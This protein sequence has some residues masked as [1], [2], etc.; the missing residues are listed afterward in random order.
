MTRFRRLRQMCLLATLLSK[1]K[2]RKRYKRQ[3]MDQH[4]ALEFS[5]LK[6][7]FLTSNSNIQVLDVR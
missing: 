5:A 1:P 4:F 2:P 3:R 7:P 6:K